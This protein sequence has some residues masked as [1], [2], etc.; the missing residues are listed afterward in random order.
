MIQKT[1]H[2]KR[3]KQLLAVLAAEPDQDRRIEHAKSRRSMA[4]EAQERR[5]DEDRHQTK[6]ADIEAGRDQ[7]IHRK[8]R[9][10]EV[11]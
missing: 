7:D 5:R 8:R 11:D 1:E 6:Q 10:G 2:Q 9:S 4:G 3:R